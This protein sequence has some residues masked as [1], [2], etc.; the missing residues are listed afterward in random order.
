MDLEVKGVPVSATVVYNLCGLLDTAEC[1]ADFGSSRAFA[2]DDNKKCYNLLPRNDSSKAYL[3]SKETPDLKDTDGFVFA[4]TDSNFKAELICDPEAAIPDFR[5]EGPVLKV[6]SK[7]ACG[8]VDQVS[9]YISQNKVVACLIII[10]IGLT[11]LFF[12]GV[13]WDLI[14]GIFGFLFGTGA[15]LFFF[16]TVVNYNSTST[17]FAIIGVLAVVIGGILAYLAYNATAISYIIIGFP[18]GYLL[19]ALLLMFLKASF[20]DVC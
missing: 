11:L 19:T 12:G 9:K 1:G 3:R 18:S 17:S 14:L 16:F 8:S 6:P 2:V 10:L 13:Q 4:S 20:E 7:D 15:V 5:F